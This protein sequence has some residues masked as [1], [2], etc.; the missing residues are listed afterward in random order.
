MGFRI[1]PVFNSTEEK[2]AFIQ[3]F[4]RDHALVKESQWDDLYSLMSI[5]LHLSVYLYFLKFLHQIL[6]V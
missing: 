1:H 3:E 6:L 2:D 5:H 4:G